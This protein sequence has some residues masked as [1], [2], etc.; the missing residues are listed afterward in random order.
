MQHKT[1]CCQSSRALPT[2]AP[3]VGE[4]TNN[5]LEVEPLRN[6]CNHETTARVEPSQ[7][8]Q[9]ALDSHIQHTNRVLCVSRHL[10][11]Y[12]KSPGDALAVE[13][14]KQIDELQGVPE[15][16]PKGELSPKLSLLELRSH[17]CVVDVSPTLL[18]ASRT[19]HKNP[20]RRERGNTRTGH[21]APNRDAHRQETVRKTDRECL[22]ERERE[23][24]TQADKTDRQAS[25]SRTEEGDPCP[26]LRA[27]Y[28]DLVNVYGKKLSFNQTRA[29]Q[30]HIGPTPYRHLDPLMQ[31]LPRPHHFNRA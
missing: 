11:V 5:R 19:Q 7:K 4:T 13:V 8:T 25:T 18:C 2:A 1:R 6:S 12:D 23:R 22:C 9:L 15:S 28:L 31:N 17:G 30:L 21:Q 29:V 26:V 3:Q 16:P 24:Q 14:V 27:R 10:P 20:P